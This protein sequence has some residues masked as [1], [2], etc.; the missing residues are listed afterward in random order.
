MCKCYVLLFNK[1]LMPFHLCP[2]VL[3][4]IFRSQDKHKQYGLK[5]SHVHVKCWYGMAHF[6]KLFVHHSTPVCTPMLDIIGFNHG[7]GRGHSTLY[8]TCKH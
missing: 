6:N 1:Y 4:V 7:L 2:S 3:Y 8:S 5:H